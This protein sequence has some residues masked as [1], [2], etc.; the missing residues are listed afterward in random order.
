MSFRDKFKAAKIS[1]LNEQQNEVSQKKGLGDDFLSINP[2]DNKFRIFPPHPETKSFIYPITKH[3]LYREAWMQNDKDEKYNPTEDEKKTL[4]RVIKKKTIFN[5]K[6]HFDSKK[7]DV[8]EEY[9]RFA[10]DWISELPQET[11]KQKQRVI[12]CKKALADIKPQTSWV[13]YAEKIS[14]SGNEFGRVEITN[15]VKEKLNQLVNSEN[16]DEPI[17]TDPFSD[18]DTGR[19]VQIT[20]NKEHANNN[21]VYSVGY[22]IKGL[23]VESY[24]LTEESLTKFM[25]NR[26]LE[27]VYVKSYTKKDYDLAIAGLQLFE[28]QTGFEVFENDM[29]WDVAE[30]IALYYPEVTDKNTTSTVSEEPKE[31]VQITLADE[32]AEEALVAE[33]DSS[34]NPYGLLDMNREELKAF[35]QKNFLQFIVNKDMTDDDIRENIIE[36]MMLKDDEEEETPVISEEPGV[37][38]EVKKEE[39]VEE[40]KTVTTSSKLTVDKMAEIRAKIAAKNKK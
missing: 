31:R 38:E 32:E 14:K 8:I 5:S 9:M 22:V 28:Q 10:E 15:G 20:Y 11:E 17:E 35:K 39:K 33:P 34:E 6:R 30:K 25:E 4:K 18:P 24:P 12:D 27:E 21:L 7:E 23:T 16:S 3:W 36:Y 2:G 37:I 40:S 26:P 29:F 19:V 1:D 13:F